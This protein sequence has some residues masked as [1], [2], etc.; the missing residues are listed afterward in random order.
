MPLLMPPDEGTCPA[1]GIVHDNFMPHYATSLYYKYRFYALRGRWPTWADAAAHCVPDMQ[2]DLKVMLS[3]Q[4]LWT[5]P[6]DGQPIADPP[7]ECVRQPIGNALSPE[8][9][10]N[11]E[12]FQLA[13]GIVNAGAKI[14]VT[15]I[16]ELSVAGVKKWIAEHEAVLRAGLENARDRC[17]LDPI[18]WKLPQFTDVWNS[19][20]WLG[21]VLLKLGA[22]PQQKRDICFCH[23]QRSCHEDPIEVAARYA[24]EFSYNGAVLDQPGEELALRIIEGR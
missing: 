16:G 4:G 2:A 19:G 23:G 13:P 14:K 3:E 17:L 1:C 21:E 7:G 15:C 24:L 10:P 12:E 22:T 20:C 8:F 11:G 9:G 5:E 18:V 6:E